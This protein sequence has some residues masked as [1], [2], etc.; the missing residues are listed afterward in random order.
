MLSLEVWYLSSRL[1]MLMPRASPPP[2]SLS[3]RAC[4]RARV[5]VCGGG[6]FLVSPPPTSCSQ[7]PLLCKL[8]MCGSLYISYDTD[9]YVKVGT[10]YL[11]FAVMCTNLDT[12]TL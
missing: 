6:G 11:Y 2:L 5:C 3:L 7:Q 9:M 8:L 10:V 12:T 1:A 4:V